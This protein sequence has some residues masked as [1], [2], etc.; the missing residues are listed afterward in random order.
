MTY[1]LLHPKFESCPPPL[2]RPTSDPAD[3]G[4][5]SRHRGRGAR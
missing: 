1:R 4:N 5:G 3:P 2:R